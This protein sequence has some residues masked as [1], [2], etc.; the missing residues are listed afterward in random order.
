MSN[1]KGY[2]NSLNSW[3]DKKDV[4]ILNELFSWTIL[5]PSK[6]RIKFK[7]ESSNYATKSDFNPFNPGMLAATF[8]EQKLQYSTSNVQS[9]ISP[10]ISGEWIWNFHPFL[11]IHQKK[12]SCKKKILVMLLYGHVVK[13]TENWN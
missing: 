13:S 10:E 11:L 8:R 6:N 5:T 3:I 12:F 7:T 9:K 2:D 4:A 1:G